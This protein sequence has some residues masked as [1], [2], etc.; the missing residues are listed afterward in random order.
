M[1]SGTPTYTRT[2][3]RLFVIRVGVLFILHILV[4][5]HRTCRL[6]RGVF[7]AADG[8]LVALDLLLS[9]SPPFTRVQIPPEDHLA[10][11]GRTTAISVL[12]YT[13]VPSLI[14]ASEKKY[15]KT[16]LAAATA[17][18][19]QRSAAAMLQGRAYVALALLAARYFYVA[20]TQFVAKN[21]SPATIT[22]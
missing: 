6:K 16:A 7:R 14:T 22:V 17:L 18:A 12:T 2:Q 3:L 8:L 15:K 13:L 10:V 4:R 21:S 9:A 11:L 19:M 5:A 20:A 1:L